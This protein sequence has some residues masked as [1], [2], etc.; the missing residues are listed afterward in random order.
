[1]SQT[2]PL[3]SNA[4]RAASAGAP[5]SAAAD[6][7]SGLVTLLLMLSGTFMVVLDFFIVNVALPAIQHDLRATSSALQL[8]VIGYGLANAAMLIT[9][10]RLGD[11]YGRRRLFAI[12]IA[13]FTAASAACGLAPNAEVLIAARVVQG[14]AGALLQPQVLAMLGML[15]SG[16]ARTRAFAAY[17]L[18]L[19]LGAASGQLIGGVL[20][21]A[22]LF[23]LGW[24]SCFLINVPIGVIALALT[25]RLLPALRGSAGHG[26]AA[27]S[28]LDVP[29][30]LLVAA[31]LTAAV[32]PLAQGREQGWPLWSVISLA[33]ALPLLAS[34]WRYQQRLAARG[35][36]PL[37]A[38]ALLAPGPFVLGLLVTLVFYSSNA[39]FYFV[40]A[41]YLQQGLGLTPLASGLVFTTLAAGFFATSMASP[42]IAQRLGRHAIF[43]GALVLAAGHALLFVLLPELTADHVAWMLPALLVQGCGLG[44]VMAPLV[45]TVL[46]GLP[47]QHAGV[48]SG[49]LA[50]TQQ[51]GNALGVALIGILYYGVLG[52]AGS[53]PAEQHRHAVA[54]AFGAGLVYLFALAIGVAW[55]Y[56]RF[57]RAAIAASAGH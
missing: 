43:V 38:P 24:R 13:L 2:A 20:I 15:Y 28:R 14:V 40:L 6:R 11:L 23:E 57:S 54:Q 42:R 55:L 33:A 50:T 5:P 47:A 21:A 12:G 45:A 46:A 44:M 51:V 25:P 48:A 27:T 7:G 32:F 36:S 26:A 52:H 35:G 39:S 10:G 31:A 29:G 4:P 17:G 22:D 41:L 56:R 34:F 49:V 30:M 8:V 1:M 3:V 9:G 18:A 37:I 16:A 53:A 19:G